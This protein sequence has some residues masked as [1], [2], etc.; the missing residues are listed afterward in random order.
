[1]AAVGL[2]ACG[3]GAKFGGGKDGAASA[4]FTSS[5]GTK[6]ASG[7]LLANL[8]NGA[9]TG[10]ISVNCQFGGSASLTAVS[11]NVTNSNISESLTITLDGTINT[12]TA[13][14]AYANE[15]INITAGVLVADD[16][17]P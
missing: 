3:H 13:S 8:A 11:V 15:S 10:D 9:G 5:S 7:A 1:V 4:L 14:Y 16:S 6:G 2:V 17:K 12:S